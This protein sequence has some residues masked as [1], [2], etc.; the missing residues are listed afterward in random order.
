MIIRV[1]KQEVVR[2]EEVV[3]SR[4]LRDHS[5]SLY[6]LHV[7][8]SC[9]SNSEFQRPTAPERREIMLLTRILAHSRI[10]GKNM[11]VQRN[12]PRLIYG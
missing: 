9:H 10:L 8:S 12:E 7:R 3:I 2:Y 5:K 6:Q 1:W 11:I 4:I